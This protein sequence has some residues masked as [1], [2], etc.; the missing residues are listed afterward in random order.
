MYFK[1]DE[2]RRK[3]RHIQHKWQNRTNAI[4]KE[5]GLHPIDSFPKTSWVFPDDPLT[6]KTFIIY[7]EI[8]EIEQMSAS[9]FLLYLFRN[10]LMYEC[11]LIFDNN[12]LLD[13]LIDTIKVK[14]S[15]FRRVIW[16]YKIS[17][18]KDCTREKNTLFF[19]FDR[20]LLFSLNKTYQRHERGGDAKSRQYILFNFYVVISAFDHLSVK[21]KDF[22]VYIL[23]YYHY[24]KTPIIMQSFPR[25]LN[26][27]N[28]TLHEGKQKAIDRINK[29]FQH[30][31]RLGLIGGSFHGYHFIVEDLKCTKP[32]NLR[33]NR[34]DFYKEK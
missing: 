9:D 20:E 14:V 5:R 1:N 23:K 30:L 21:C 27:C 11:N 33:L 19:H 4:R 25:L 6:L 10:M 17:D 31:D 16:T 7:D 15:D 22:L 29:Y 28:I 26:E 24:G 32:L 8:K 3:M 18:I 12:I 13:Y 2:Q 34:I